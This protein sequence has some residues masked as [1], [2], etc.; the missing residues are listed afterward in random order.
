MPR[1]RAPTHGKIQDLNVTR[2]LSSNQEA[3]NLAILLANPARHVS[4][5]NALVIQTGPLRNFGIPFE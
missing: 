3:D 2:N 5:C 4:S 1:R